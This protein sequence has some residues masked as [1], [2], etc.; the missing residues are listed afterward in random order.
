MNHKH[1]LSISEARKK[2]FGLAEEVQKPGQY[3]TFTEKGRPKVVFMSAEE[4]ESWV[5]TMELIKDFPDLDKDLAELK[6]DLKTGVYK[7]YVTLDEILAK[8]GYI[9]AD[10]AKKQHG[11]RAHPP[12]KRRKRP[13]TVGNKR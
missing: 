2:I 9:L 12:T 11:I 7:N 5:E 13:Q 4:F 8:E 10:K 3:Y 1:T 6:K